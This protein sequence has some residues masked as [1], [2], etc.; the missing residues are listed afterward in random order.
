MVM[1]AIRAIGDTISKQAVHP[2]EAPRRVEAAQTR[3]I[4]PEHKRQA[5]KVAQILQ[6]NLNTFDVKLDYSV[7]ESTGTIVVKVING[8]TGKVVREIPPKELLALAESI[9]EELHGLLYDE[10]M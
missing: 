10:R 5:Q 4:S 7:H 9:V 6:E 2:S 8:E 1:E 3:D